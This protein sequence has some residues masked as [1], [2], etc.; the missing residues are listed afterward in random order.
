MIVT[1]PSFEKI[2]APP[3]FV[4]CKLKIIE[5]WHGQQKRIQYN[6]KACHLFSV[7]TI[8]IHVSLDSILLCRP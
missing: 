3:D 7:V 1:F 6:A 8:S 4:P 2:V 5:I